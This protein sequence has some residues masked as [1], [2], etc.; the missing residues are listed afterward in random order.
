MPLHHWQVFIRPLARG[1]HPYVPGEQPKIKGLIELNTSE[2]PCPP[3]ARVLAA[4]R[5]AVDVRL[6]P[7]PNP[8]VQLLREMLARKGG[9]P[10]GWCGCQPRVGG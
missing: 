9:Q 8:T 2:N 4:T 7:Y 1:L 6:R 5:A 10:L 3:P